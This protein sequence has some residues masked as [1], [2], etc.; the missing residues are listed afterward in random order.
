MSKGVC[1]RGGVRVDGPCAILSGIHTFSSTLGTWRAVNVPG[2]VRVELGFAAEIMS[3]APLRP[4]P[5]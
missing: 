5:N 1:A 4:A 3:R 2:H